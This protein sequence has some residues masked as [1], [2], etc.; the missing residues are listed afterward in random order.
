MAA[1]DL[2]IQLDEPRKVYVGGETIS[3]TVIVQCQAPVKCSGLELTSYWSTHG[4]GNIATGDID[5]QTLFQGEWDSNKEYRYPF[6]LKIAAWPPTYYG[7]YLNVSHSV[8]ARA[9]LPWKSD[10]K[11]EVEF[12][13]VSLTAPEDLKPTV[14]APKKSNSIIGW[15]FGWIIAGI[16]LL[17]FLPLLGM[18]LVFILPLI[19]I[20]GAT[21]WF[22]RV[23]LPSQVTGSIECTVEPK[24]VVAG[25]SI[26]GQLRFTPK[27]N[28]SINSIHWTMSCLEKCSSGSGSNR[29]TYSHEIMKQT[30][31]LS[32]QGQLKFGEPQSFEFA[33]PVPENA[34]PSLK[35]NDNELLWSCDMR[36]DI[37]RWP[38]WVKSVPVTVIPSGKSEIGPSRGVLAK[39][40]TAVPTSEDEQWFNEVLEQISRCEDGQ[41][42][43]IV[44]EAVRDQVFV[45]CVDVIEHMDEP[46]VSYQGPAGRWI[47]AVPRRSDVEVALLWT[48]P[49][50]PPDVDTMNWCGQATI[51]GYDEQI[52]CLLMRL[53]PPQ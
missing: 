16:L 4:R 20:G 9:K 8:R 13:V 18:L 46:P 48:L 34:P 51:I 19:A 52:E 41:Q 44:V 29:K 47:I 38:D 17:V 1:C 10:P 28:V 53:L 25:E 43:G 50:E 45:I 12:P 42:I 26:R 24:R 11:T 30:E 2:K 23:F 31:Q 36:I 32:G 3:G 15:V 35:F 27:R 33:F 39:S 21:Y 7:T 49:G 5:N 40:S 37:A 6:T 22:F 14:G